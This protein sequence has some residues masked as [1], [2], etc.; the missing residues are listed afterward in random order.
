MNG[1]RYIEAT[2]QMWWQDCFKQRAH[3]FFTD[4][5]EFNTGNTD[6]KLGVGEQGKKR[7][8]FLLSLRGYWH[9]FGL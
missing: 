1:L 9:R 6:A 4:N 3:L 8:A 5:S 2:Q 7:Y